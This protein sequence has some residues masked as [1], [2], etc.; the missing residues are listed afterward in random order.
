MVDADG[1]GGT[2][3]VKMKVSEITMEKATPFRNAYQGGLDAGMETQA[4]RAQFEDS[5]SLGD[6]TCKGVMSRECFKFL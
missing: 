3:V 2:W 1:R 5:C 4:S 6:I